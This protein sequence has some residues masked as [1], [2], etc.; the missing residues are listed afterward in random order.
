MSRIAPSFAAVLLALGLAAA[1]QAQEPAISRQVLPNGLTVLVR[2]DAAAGVVAMSLQVRAGSRFESPTNTGITNFLHRVMLRGTSKRTAVQ[3]AACGLLVAIVHAG[4]LV[5]VGR[6]SPTVSARLAVSPLGTGGVLGLVVTGLAVVALVVALAPAPAPPSG[7]SAERAR[8]A[9]LAAHPGADS[10][11]PFATRADKTYAFSPDGGSAIGYR[12]VWGTA[13][14]GGDPVGAEAAADAAIAAFL[15]TCTRNGW[16]PAVL[17]A[18]AAV[19]D[20][21]RAQGVRRG[22]AIGDE[23]VLDV[24]SFALASRRMRNVRQAVQR[25]R[26]AGLT[27]HVGPG[28]AA[29]PGHLEPVLRDWLRGRPERGF[30]MNLDGLLRPRPD[31]VVAVAY[32]RSGVAQGFARFAVGAAGRMLTLDAAPRRTRAPNGV[33]ERLIVEVVEYG[34]AR[35]VAEM[36]LNFAGFRRVYAGSGPVVRIAAGLAHVLDRWIELDSLYRFTAKFRPHWR[37]RSVL[38]RSWLDIGWV[39]AAAL[40]AEFGRSRGRPAA[41]EGE[42]APETAPT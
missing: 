4:W 7:G 15:D 36:S 3:I 28:D 30:A 5:A 11:A 18:G 16:R 10:L 2:E 17:G 8:V 38:M 6:D 9:A 20:R 31:C 13:L 26:N 22:V 29:P 32:D 14:A 27:V 33:V 12:V 19:V 21:W 24:A 37:P 25:T 34:R 39:G 23:A 41:T 1:A 35:G 40:R 42:L